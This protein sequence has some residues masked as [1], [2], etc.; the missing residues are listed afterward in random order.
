MGEAAYWEAGAGRLRT[1]DAR[2]RGSP[3]Q[4]KGSEKHSDEQWTL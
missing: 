4:L 2:G 3:W 1:I